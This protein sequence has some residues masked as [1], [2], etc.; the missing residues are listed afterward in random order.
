LREISPYTASSN[1]HY[2]TLGKMKAMGPH[3]FDPKN[4]PVLEDE[5]RRVWQDPEKI[6]AMIEIKPSYI[7]ADLGCGSGFFTVPLSQKVK[8]VYGIDVQKEMLD[9]L[10]EKI[11]KLKIEN[12]ELLLSKGDEIPLENKSVDL[13]ISVNTL[14]E[15]DSKEKMIQELKRVLKEGGRVMILDFKKE[16]TGFGPPVTIRVARD[17]ATILF[18]KKG[19]TLSQT[20]DMRYHYLLVFSK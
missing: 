4:I 12:V 2:I 11:R 14:H 5:N 15:F 7:A 13:L 6:L 1:N 20:Q 18:K 19:F 9:F 17:E 3:V 16:E 8:K 10:G